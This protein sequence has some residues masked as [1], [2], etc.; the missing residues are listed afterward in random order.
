MIR[1]KAEKECFDLVKVRNRTQEQT[2]RYFYLY[3][4]LRDASFK[5][6]KE[7]AKKIDVSSRALKGNLTLPSQL[8]L[9]EKRKPKQNKTSKIKPQPKLI[10]LSMPKKRLK[11]APPVRDS[12]K[13]DAFHNPI[14]IVLV[15][16]VPWSMRELAKKGI[17]SGG[18]EHAMIG[19][20]GYKGLTI[21]KYGT[22]IAIYSKDGVDYKRTELKLEGYADGTVKRKWGELGFTKRV[23]VIDENGNY[24][25]SD[26]IAQ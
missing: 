21:K 26:I 23:E 9:E 18:I 13:I 5:W 1:S 3:N 25:N 22:A 16:G 8:A 15:N 17:S 12:E 10:T 4:A 24:L 19:N 14:K 20:R 11:I 7:E 2:D 6:E